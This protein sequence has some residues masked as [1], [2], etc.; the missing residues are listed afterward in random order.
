M[1]MTKQHWGVALV[2]AVLV[3]AYSWHDGTGW[4][5]WTMF[6]K[7]QTYRLSIVVTDE[8]GQRHFV[9]PTELARFVSP[10]TAPYL[11]GAERFRHA[12]VG[13]TLR[14]ALSALG[15]LA[16]STV[17]QATLAS[18]AIEIRRTLNSP[19]ERTSADVPCARS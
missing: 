16:C 2:V 3:P 11:T 15:G 8:N 12:P 7:S 10:D 1:A 19:V 13:L 4:L 6:S 17:P 9:N 14:D 18:I 5:A